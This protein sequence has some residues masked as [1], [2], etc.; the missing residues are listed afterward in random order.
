MTDYFDDNS[1]RDLIKYRGQR[2]KNALDEAALLFEFHIPRTQ[3]IDGAIYRR[4]GNIN[5]QK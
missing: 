2:S 1:R 4:S 5:Q 3:T